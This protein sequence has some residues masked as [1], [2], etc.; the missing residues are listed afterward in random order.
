MAEFINSKSGKVAD[1][2]AAKSI[3]TFK[4]LITAS[5]V[6]TKDYGGVIGEVRGGTLDGKRYD[7]IGEKPHALSFVPKRYIQD[8]DQAGEF[9]GLQTFTDLSGIITGSITRD[10]DNG[11]V[12]VPITLGAFLKNKVGVGSTISQ[13]LSAKR[14]PSASQAY[15]QISSSLI[16]LFSNV[17]PTASVTYA[18]Q[19]FYTTP[20]ASL[21]A[22]NVA[23]FTASLTI[24]T[25]H[26]ASNIFTE[27]FSGI[28]TDGS[29]VVLIADAR[30]SVSATNLIF[31]S[32]KADIYHNLFFT[33]SEFI[34]FNSAAANLTSSF[35]T[36]KDH[37]ISFATFI[38]KSDFLNGAAFPAATGST[39]NSGS[40]IIPFGANSDRN[41]NGSNT[42]DG[43]YAIST[44]KG[45]VTGDGNSGSLYE[46]F[47][48][49]KNPTTGLDQNGIELVIYPAGT[50][51]LSASFHHKAYSILPQFGISSAQLRT[52]TAS[53]DIRTLYY[54]S[55]STTPGFAGLFTGS[56]NGTQLGSL[57]HADP[58]LK[59]TA[60]YGY[61]S[62]S[63]SNTA[64][65]S[66]GTASKDNA[67]TDMGSTAMKV[68]RISAS[69][70]L[71]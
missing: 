59:T 41:I 60:S 52:V 35:A 69:F 20:S 62:I 53:A 39:S 11:I 28:D 8:G 51:V 26:S 46:F 3:D 63:G 37:N 38:T 6:S 40:G 25:K 44:F 10:S 33:A 15:L 16:N 23:P 2:R 1:N 31:R 68:P 4:A 36:G 7:F 22:S 70:A 19:E 64:V 18:A 32:T 30:N 43:T 67:G 58:E 12:Y 21:S 9:P 49:G 56:S 71:S 55:S 5:G 29:G 13:S 61:Y 17:S 24:A 42:S 66:V 47:N 54:V 57:L 50:K 45:I 27:S 48:F 14:A 34:F 65:F